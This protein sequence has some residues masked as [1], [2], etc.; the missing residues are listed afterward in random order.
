MLNEI[1][2][3]TEVKVGEKVFPVIIRQLSLDMIEPNWWN[4]N[5]MKPKEF[6]FLI[7][8][9]QD[10][11]F[12]TAILVR[13]HKA[14]DGREIFQIVD[15]EH[16]FKAAKQLNFESVICWDMGE[17]DEDIAQ[18]VTYNQ[19]HIKGDEDNIEFSKI[20]SQNKQ[21]GLFAI[22][23]K[24]A[25]ALKQ[26]LGFDFKQYD[27]TDIKERTQDEKE[28]FAPVMQ[29]A[30][31]L[32]NQLDAIKMYVKPDEAWSLCMHLYDVVSQVTKLYSE[33]NIKVT[34]IDENQK[35][36]FEEEKQEQ[37]V[38]ETV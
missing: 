24:K 38:A 16:R 37:K 19:N 36:L 7:K 30:W 26:I 31:K 13:P 22:D 4:K 1:I 8:S 15:G 3:Q 25:E 34:K 2:G 27:T 14:F 6:D 20:Y 33:K 35:A 5:R 9:M 18:A 29:T 12:T 10:Y 28:L 17:L 21:P 23:E 32:Q 11:G